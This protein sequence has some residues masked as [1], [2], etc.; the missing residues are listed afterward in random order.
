MCFRKVKV[1]NDVRKKLKY[2]EDKFYEN[3]S[4]SIVYC[5]FIKTGVHNRR[6]V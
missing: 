5:I 1:K 4:V 6:I 2:F 3:F